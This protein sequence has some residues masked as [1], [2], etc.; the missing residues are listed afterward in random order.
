M[1]VEP[2]ELFERARA[3]QDPEQAGA[4]YQQL[5]GL[6]PGYP[7]AAYRLGMLLHQQGKLAEAQ[8]AYRQELSLRPDFWACRANLAQ[9]LYEQAEFT[10]A[11]QQ[12]QLAKAHCPHPEARV[13]LLQLEA[14]LYRRLNQPQSALSCLRSAVEIQNT[15]ELQRDLARTSL[16][17]GQAETARKYYQ[18]ALLLGASPLLRLEAA[19]YFSSLQRYPEALVIYEQVLTAE[20]G[21]ERRAL[22]WGQIANAHQ[23]LNQP[24]QAQQAYDQALAESAGDALRLA[25]ALVM[26]VIY[27][28]K[29]EISVWYQAVQQELGSL[30]QL[31]ISQPF[32]IAALPFY[33]AY[34]GTDVLPILTRL[35]ELYQ[36]FLPE[37]PAYQGQLRLRQGRLR[38][39]C[40]SHFFYKHSVMNCFAGILASLTEAP[41]ELH[42]FAASSLIE[43][44]LTQRLRAAAASW[45]RLQGSLQQQVETIRAQEL[46][47]LLYSDMGLDPHSYALAHYRMAPLQ[48]VLPGQPLSSGIASLDGFISDVLSEPPQAQ[49]HYCERLIQL[50]QMPTLYPRPQLRLAA[51]GR[52]HWG[53]SEQQTLYLYPGQAF[54]LHPEMD[55]AF[56]QILLNDP[57]ACLILLD[58]TANGLIRDV[59]KRLRGSLR[60]QEYQ[61]IRVLPAQP[62]DAFAALLGCVDLVLEAAPFGSF[63]TLMTA[64]ALGIP[65][66]SFPGDYLRGRYCLAS[67]RQLGIE[68]ALASSWPDYAQQA[69]ELAHNPRRRQQ[70]GREILL[71]QPRLFNNLPIVAEF[72]TCL[73]QLY[74]S[75]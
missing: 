43:D 48:L 9:L 63:N 50:S 12:I 57:S 51:L 18:A 74:K 56:E 46:D 2:A 29:N 37:V 6:E 10:R 55:Q 45:T 69:L 8:I 32:E 61:R 75:L 25:R 59:L 11:L 62:A 13:G 36:A 44:A 66:L 5:L 40:V 4:L 17:L 24:R 35:S 54:K 31:E 60:K 38:V 19:E 3:E 23:E 73:Q 70:I 22:I 47:I 34:Q 58:L 65:V 30:N 15:P 71:A 72:K 28:D 14:R 42:C 26:P 67:Y 41:F 49:E 1:Q 21:P 68:G 39:G 52:S 27:R 33:L 64:F 7:N 53:F 20:L 16:L